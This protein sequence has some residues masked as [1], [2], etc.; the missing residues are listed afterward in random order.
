M[1]FIK[2]NKILLIV[3]IAIT[4]KMNYSAFIT[5][6]KKSTMNAMESFIDTIMVDIQEKA[7]YMIKT[8][9]EAKKDDAIL[10]PPGWKSTKDFNIRKSHCCFAIYRLYLKK[11]SMRLG[12]SEKAAQN[13][14]E[15]IYSD[16]YLS[17]NEK[18]NKDALQFYDAFSQDCLE[19]MLGILTNLYPE[20]KDVFMDGFVNQ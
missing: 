15:I 3:K 13:D 7:F 16:K 10:F 5:D 20:Q 17:I 8:E 12:D 11:V 6:I 18:Y 14:L 4:A 19:W 1:L 9:Y 2:I